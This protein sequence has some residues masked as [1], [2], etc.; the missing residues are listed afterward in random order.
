MLFWCT[1]PMGGIIK[2]KCTEEGLCAFNP[3]IGHCKEIAIAKANDPTN[4]FQGLSTVKENMEGFTA[5]EIAGAKAA[6]IHTGISNV[7][8]LKLSKLC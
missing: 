6:E 5:K 3:S 7:Q 4:E 8:D 1:P 2:F